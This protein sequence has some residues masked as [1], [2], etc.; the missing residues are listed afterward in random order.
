VVKRLLAIALQV[1]IA[2]GLAIY[3]P[4]PWALIAGANLAWRLGR[5]S[6]GR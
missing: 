2:L 1:G 5:W 3:A 4:F 6:G